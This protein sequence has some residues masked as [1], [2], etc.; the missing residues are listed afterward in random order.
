MKKSLFTSIVMACIFSV[1]IL[2]CNNKSSE[3]NV[4]ADIVTN[5]KTAE[6]PTAQN[7]EPILTCDKPVWD[8][9]RINEGEVVLH[10]FTFVNTGDEA[11]VVSKCQASCG[12]T[13]PKCDTKP[14]P[15]GGTGEI[16]IRFD[17]NGKKN[18]Q[19]KNVTVTAN[20]NPPETMLT[21]QGFVIPKPE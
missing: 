8:F 9:G 6:N 19:S 14:I 10:V 20:T 15:P 12:C 11:L 1:S 7:A 13:T 17:S 21:I 16:G 2:S 3:N 18:A 5:N 4:D